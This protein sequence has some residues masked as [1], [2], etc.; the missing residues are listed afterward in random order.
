MCV[1]VY[2]YIY[3]YTYIYIYMYIYIYI[4]VCVCVIYML[5]YV[6]TYIYIHT[7]TYSIHCP[8]FNMVIYNTDC[9]TPA[10]PPQAKSLSALRVADEASAST[11]AEDVEFEVIFHFV[12]EVYIHK[13]T[14]VY[15]HMSI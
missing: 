1:R 5:L 11:G 13:G 14:C 9:L 6:C 3:I 2:I 7:C 10:G 12:K 15:V 8:F 4:C